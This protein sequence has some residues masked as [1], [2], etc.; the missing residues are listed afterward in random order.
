MPGWLRAAWRAGI[1]LGDF[2]AVANSPSRPYERA[3]PPGPER[4]RLLAWQ[5]RVRLAPPEADKSAVRTLDGGPAA[6]QGGGRQTLPRIGP[7]PPA[8]GRR[9]VQARPPALTPRQRWWR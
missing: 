2:L 6:E 5:T 3:R 7:G 9:H 1:A 8:A 4:R